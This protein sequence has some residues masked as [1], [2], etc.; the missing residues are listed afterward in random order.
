ML[1]IL[2][3]GGRNRKTEQGEFTRVLYR[4]CRRSFTNT[5]RISDRGKNYEF[6]VREAACNVVR[7]MKLKNANVAWKMQ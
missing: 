5:A 6:D 1:T 4:G 3:Q 7:A 2:F